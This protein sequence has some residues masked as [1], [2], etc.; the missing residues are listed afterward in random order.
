MSFYRE[1]LENYLSEL[2]VKAGRVLDIGGASNP[3]KDRVKSW[4]VEKYDIGD[5]GLEEGKFDIH[6]DLNRE[7]KPNHFFYD[8][9]FC[10]EVFEYLYRPI[11]ALEFINGSLNTDGKA[12]ISFPFVYPLHEP[13]E[14]DYLRYTKYGVIKLL[15]EAGF[16]NI[17]LIPRRTKTPSLQRYYAED[18]MHPA[19][20]EEHDITGWI[21]E[22]TK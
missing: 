9:V 19:K 22:V 6:I 11:R 1:T 16:K 4:E 7:P 3:V 5:N 18:G 2:D 8:M 20:G 17:N 14:N 12:I 13:K 21:A 15:E 10:L